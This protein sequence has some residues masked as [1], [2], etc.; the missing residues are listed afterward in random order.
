MS[1]QCIHLISR[2]SQIKIG[3]IN[4]FRLPEIFL[5]FLIFIYHGFVQLGKTRLF[6][7]TIHKVLAK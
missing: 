6:F 2:T 5:Y 1:L 3:E 4:F 7:F